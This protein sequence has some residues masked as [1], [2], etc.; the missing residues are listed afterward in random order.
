MNTLDWIVL[1]LP[2]LVVIYFACKAQKHVKGVADFLSAGRIAGR[3]VLCIASGEAGFGLIS[4]AGLMEQ[5][6]NC[7]FAVSFW[8]AI[9]VTLGMVLALF[10]FATY[11]FR[12]TRAMTLG[13]FFEIRYNRPFRLIDG[14][15]HSGDVRPFELRDFFRRSGRVVSCTFWACRYPSR[16]SGA[17]FRHLDC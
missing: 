2:I 4:F 6:Y 7:G 12:E 1:F 9:A 16:F 15:G 10:G 17:S 13:Q 5:Y 14:G 3:Y 11:R 8:S